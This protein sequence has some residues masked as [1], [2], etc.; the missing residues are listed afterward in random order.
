MTSAARGSKRL[1]D[2]THLPLLLL[3]TFPNRRRS[4]E[5][6][7]SVTRP[8]MKNE[9]AIK[10]RFDGRSLRLL[11]VSNTSTSMQKLRRTIL[12]NSLKLCLV[13]LALVPPLASSFSFPRTTQRA[14]LYFEKIKSRYPTIT[15]DPSNH[16]EKNGFIRETSTSLAST[17][18]STSSSSEKE[19]DDRA[20]GILVLLTVP[21]A[22]GTYAPVVKYVYEMDPPVPGLVFSAGYYIVAAITLT[23]LNIFM[24]E[25]QRE[26]GKESDGMDELLLDVQD[27]VAT[28]GILSMSTL[29]GI[30]LGSY[31][32]LGNCL[33]VVGLKTVPADRAAFLVQLTTII[34]PILDGLLKGKGGLSL[35]K[36]TTWLAC[37]VAFAGVIIMGLDSP[38]FDWTTILA[39]GTNIQ[40]LDI[41]FSVGDGLIITA[42]FAYSMHVVRLGKYAQFVTPLQLT[43][44]K[45]RVEAVL[46]FALVAI[47]FFGL[48]GTLFSDLSS[49][50][51]TYIDTMGGSSMAEGVPGDSLVSSQLWD[52]HLIFAVLWTGWVTCAYTIYAQSFGQ[53]RVS[54]TDSNLIY[55]TQPIF[56]SLFAFGL[57]GETLGA[58]GYLGGTLIGTALWIVTSSTEPLN[59]E[60]S[61]NQS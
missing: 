4:S 36:S 44:S 37:L 28:E 33:Q 11:T 14:G 47:L 54:P 21:F 18:S 2:V 31:L 7:E 46:S 38:E 51:S 27:D 43:A 55:S 58:A 60:S 23:G 8:K 25:K 20:L 9:Q 53:R 15:V 45:A 10:N 3:T 39:S 41:T 50:I 61:S 6:S 35:I 52:S 29:A 13:T 32:F 19:L 22:W 57:L 26:D 5:R 40:N 1:P 12:Q 24:N 30:E 49:E 34:V 59:V 42:A 48:P 56:S 17:P 16:V